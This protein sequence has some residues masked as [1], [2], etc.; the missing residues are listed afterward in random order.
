[1]ALVGEFVVFAADLF[2]EEAGLFN[3]DP[4]V[5]LGG[6]A[7]V[8]GE[9]NDFGGGHGLLFGSFVMLFYDGE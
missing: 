6:A 5:V 4:G 9:K 8:A 2:V 1:M 3:G 7:A